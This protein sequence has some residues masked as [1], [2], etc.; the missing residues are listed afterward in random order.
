MSEF[1][2]IVTV[3]PAYDC[4][5]VQPCVHG[6][7]ECGTRPG[8]SHGRHN[9]ELRMLL[10]NPVAEVILVVN[11][12]WDLPETPSSVRSDGGPRGAFVEFHYSVPSYEGHEPQATTCELWPACYGDVGYTMADEPARLLV[13]SGSDAV[14]EWLQAAHSDR[15]PCR[16]D[17]EGGA[18]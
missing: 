3:K 16:C 1:E 14:W 13:V 12:G 10:R 9:A 15:W 5:M 18:A 7:V 4:L 11:T 2:R 6:S 8:A 17:D